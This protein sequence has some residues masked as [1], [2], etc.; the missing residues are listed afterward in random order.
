MLVLD[1][2]LV[3]RQLPVGAV[4]NHPD[5]MVGGFRG[6]DRC[7]EVANVFV[8]RIERDIDARLILI[9]VAEVGHPQRCAIGGVPGIAA[10]FRHSD[11][12]TA[13][14]RLAHRR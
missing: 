12:R 6:I 8:E 3:G 10:E 14:E 9:A 7:P 11:I 2:Q 5:F 1:L 13:T 4:G